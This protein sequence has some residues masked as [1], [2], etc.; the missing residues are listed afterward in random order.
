MS[1]FE[2]ERFGAVIIGKSAY[3]GCVF[4]VSWILIDLL[5]TVGSQFYTKYVIRT[6]DWVFPKSSFFAFD[7][8]LEG[9]LKSK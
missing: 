2:R 7:R 8:R 1:R 6:P 4:S 5:N 3:N 9:E